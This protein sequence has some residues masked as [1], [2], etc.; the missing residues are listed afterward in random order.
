MPTI[1]SFC[2]KPLLLAT[3]VA[4]SIVM[5][6]GQASTAAPAAKPAAKKPATAGTAKTTGAK[7]A[8]AAPLSLNTKKEKVSY[9]IGAD[10]GGKLKSSS[11][12]VDPNILRSE[13]RRVGK[14]C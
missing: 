14:E 2:A 11:I 7:P 4:G 13:E 5:S 1:Q 6:H 9:A 12:D 10:L 8:A 3:F